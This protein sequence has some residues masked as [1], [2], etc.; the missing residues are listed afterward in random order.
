MVAALSANHLAALLLPADSCAVSMSHAIADPAGD[1]AHGQSARPG[2]G[3]RDRDAWPVAQLDDFNEDLRRARHRETS[4]MLCA[5]ARPG[6]RGALHGPE[7][8]A[9]TG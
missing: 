4:G 9:A 8:P 6:G 1:A 2:R 7:R 3:G 5:A